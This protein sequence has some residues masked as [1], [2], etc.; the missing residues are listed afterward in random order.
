MTDTNVDTKVNSKIISLN[1][2]VIHVEQFKFR[3]ATCDKLKDILEADE[4]FTLKFNY[5]SEHDPQNIT[6][7][8]IR[9]FVNYEQI[10]DEELAP[11]NGFIKNI[12][13]NQLSN[14]LKHMKALEYITENDE[15][16]F[17]IILEDDIVFNDN[18][19]D[20]LYDCLS[21]TPTD[22]DLYF[23]GLPSS[24]EVQGDK[25]QNVGDVFKVLPC[26]DSYII[27]KTSAEALFKSYTPIKF[28]NNIQLSY[29]IKKNN[30]KTY[31][32]VPNVFIDGSKLGLYYSSLSVNNKLIFNQDY[33]SIAKLIEEK[34][35]F[36]EEEMKVID[37]AFVGIRLKTNP[38]MFYLKAL[39]EV[40]R[41]NYEFAKAIYAYAYSLYEANGSVLNNQS[42]FLR[43]YM[44]VFKY[45][46]EDIPVA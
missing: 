34:E 43:D 31:L 25:Y 21:D 12:H 7:D 19:A 39:Y 26:C 42:T 20:I 17:S 16:E 18:V 22:Y 24:K 23:L 32:A 40:K 44:K 35:E 3:R 2:Y 14:S 46:Q 41:H 36:D 11:Y 1:I 10:K 28:S 4:R 37:A 30:F 27:T 5:I 9:Q 45:L 15:V 13:I 29:L 8:E 33:V 38:E 6:Q